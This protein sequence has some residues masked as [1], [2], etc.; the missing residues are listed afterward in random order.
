VARI[1]KGVDTGGCWRPTKY[2]RMGE[3][4]AVLIAVPT[5]L[6]KNREPDMSYIVDTCEAIAPWLRAGQLIV[7][8][9]TTYPGTTDEVMIPDSREERAQG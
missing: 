6:N 1:K 5:P 4:D 3:C 9:S 2:D 7:L 8:E